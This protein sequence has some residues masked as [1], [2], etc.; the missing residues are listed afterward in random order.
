MSKSPVEKRL[1]QLRDLW[2]EASESPALR[3]AV[4]RVPDN[5]RRMLSAF[6]EAQ[7]HSGEWNTP[8]AFLRLDAAFETSWDYSRALKRTLTTGF[9]EN[10]DALKNQG[11]EPDW[12]A[13]SQD[14]PDTAAGFMALL[15]SFAEHY[16]D[17][18][19]HVV[20]VLE[21]ERVTSPEAF[22]DWLDAALA[23]PVLREPRA[24]VRIAIT[25]TNEHPGWQALADRHKNAAQVIGA[26]VD[27]FDIAR[28]TA[29]QSGG[30]G[31]QVA[32]RLAL[33]DVMTSLEK[34]SAAQTSQ[35]ADK[36]MKRCE[37]EQWHDQQVVLHMAVAGAHLKEKQ[38]GDAIKRYR[39]ARECAARAE[40]AGHPA[41]G[42]LVLQTWFGE[43]GAWLAA[44][45]NGQAAQAYKQ[46][47]EVARRIPNV[48]FIIEGLRMA[49]YCFAKDGQRQAALD[50]GLHAIGEA[51]PLSSEDRAATTFPLLLQD[52]LRLQDP[53]RAEKIERAGARYQESVAATHRDMEAKAS[54]LGP[55]PSPQ[56]LTKLDLLLEAKLESV[57]AK[58]CEE[59]EALIARGDVFFRKLVAVGRD[60]LHRG[61]NGLPDVKHPLDKDMAEWSSPPPFG[62]LPD[63]SDLIDPSRP[64]S[65]APLP[66]PAESAA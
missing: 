13:A 19:R 37:A 46:A 38:H 62:V 30:S 21:P 23:A 65:S 49:A 26:P 3:L 55:S 10:R 27:M 16:R 47:T 44:G 51:K 43:A 12:P 53:S 8:D 14:Q 54:R 36:A 25:D 15:S 41:G 61:W 18:W 29:A 20:V 57:F 11:I 6:F 17:H 34:G 60:F 45:Q 31:P 66:A 59:R 64:V 42:T 58:L 24:R 40:A 22:E 7:Q 52:L 39:L 5:A 32:H 1:E 63:A 9:E 50:H 56:D 4:W 33:T 2:L 35:R 48:M 28:A